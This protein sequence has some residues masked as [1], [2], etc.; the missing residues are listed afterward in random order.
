LDESATTRS[1]IDVSLSTCRMP[2]GTQ[3]Q[4]QSYTRAPLPR[5]RGRTRC[6]T[7]GP[8]AARTH[9]GLALA[10]RELAG[11]LARG[12]SCKRARLLVVVARATVVLAAVP[13]LGA[14]RPREAARRLERRLAALFRGAVLLAVAVTAAATTTIVLRHAAAALLPPPALLCRG[15][16]LGLRHRTCG[17]V[18][19]HGQTSFDRNLKSSSQ[20]SS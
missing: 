1:L 6:S 7:R 8:C 13:E 11:L 17:F 15:L 19:Q 10:L 16:V 4:A 20:L 18:G 14:Q 9:Q 2:H 5:A 3:D 12:E